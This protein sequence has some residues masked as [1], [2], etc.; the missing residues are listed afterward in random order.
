MLIVE[1]KANLFFGMV[2]EV[3]LENSLES[4]PEMFVSGAGSDGTECLQRFAIPRRR[5][6]RGREKIQFWGQPIGCRTDLRE[7]SVK[8][9]DKPV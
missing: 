8:S 4:S 3:N 2:L 6:W 9:R 1:P 5:V 7:L